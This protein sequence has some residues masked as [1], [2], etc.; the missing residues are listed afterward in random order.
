M[1]TIRSIAAAFAGL[2]TS[3]HSIVAAPLI[4]VS[5][6]DTVITQSCVVEIASV[7]EDANQNGVLHIKAD[8][9]TVRFKNGSA[10]RGATGLTAAAC[11]APPPASAPRSCGSARPT[12]PTAARAPAARAA[13]LVSRLSTGSPED[14]VQQLVGKRWEE[15]NTENLADLGDFEGYQ[16]SFLRLFGFGLSGVDYAADSDPGVGVPSLKS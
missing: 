3:L 2:A 7:V 11:C 9:I 14:K 5:K 12:T 15:V 4:T 16:S 13:A 1:T 8:N 10:L 6:D